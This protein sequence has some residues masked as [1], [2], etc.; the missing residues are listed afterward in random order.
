MNRLEAENIGKD[1][2]G[3]LGLLIMDTAYGPQNNHEV[4]K[5]EVRLAANITSA[6]LPLLV[7]YLQSI[8]PGVVN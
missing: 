4:G 8:Q 6:I 3:K 2:C 5:A 7:D 1:F